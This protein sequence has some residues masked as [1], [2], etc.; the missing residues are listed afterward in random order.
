MNCSNYC[1]EFIVKQLRNEFVLWQSECQN[2]IL[3]QEGGKGE[4]GTKNSVWSRIRMT[5]NTV[6]N[7]PV[8]EHRPTSK[9]AYGAA[10]QN[11][12]PTHSAT[13]AGGTKSPNRWFPKTAQALLYHLHL[14][15]KQF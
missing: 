1:R 5:T 8:R 11:T 14:Y 15:A 3:Q 9:G 10:T 2:I 13:L 6:H 12:E 4:R 7:E